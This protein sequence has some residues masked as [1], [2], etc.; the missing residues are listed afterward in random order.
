MD[1]SLRKKAKKISTRTD[2]LIHTK[3]SFA[4]TEYQIY[5]S[6]IF[7]NSLLLEAPEGKRREMFS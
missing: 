4:L 5:I 7:D 3:S 1:M 2:K 6:K